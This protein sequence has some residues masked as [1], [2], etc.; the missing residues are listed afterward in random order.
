MLGRENLV[1]VTNY[2]KM[3]IKLRPYLFQVSLYTKT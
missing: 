1:G 2:W 3:I